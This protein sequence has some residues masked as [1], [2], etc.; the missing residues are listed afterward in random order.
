MRNLP[1][2]VVSFW[3]AALTG[4]IVVPL[5]SWWTGGEL[6]YALRDAGV[7]VV[8]VDDER[9]ERIVGRRPPRG[10]STSSACGPTAATCR[11][12]S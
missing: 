4:A 1:E 7:S 5:N 3:G 11:S 12:T 8:F 2:F 10:V 6:A 9:L